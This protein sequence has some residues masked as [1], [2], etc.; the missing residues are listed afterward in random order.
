MKLNRYNRLQIITAALEASFRERVEAHNAVRLALL[1]QVWTATYSPAERTAARQLDAANWFSR[2]SYITLNAGGW[3]LMLS[4][5]DFK[6]PWSYQHRHER[7]DLK[8]PALV[9]AARRYADADE[10]LKKDRSAAEGALKTLLGSCSSAEM[11]EKTWP[12]GRPFYAHLLG[13]PS[14]SRLPAVQVE[15]VNRLLGL[16]GDVDVANNPAG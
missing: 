16:Q 12:E 10:A 4:T 6:L 7:I 15:E 8:Q 13:R 1:E 9:E 11:L 2:G 3:R 5:V 14:Q